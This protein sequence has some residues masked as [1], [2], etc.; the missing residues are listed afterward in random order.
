MLYQNLFI[1]LISLHRPHVFLVLS[2]SLQTPFLF[3]HFVTLQPY[4]KMYTFFPSSI[5]TQ[6]YIMTK[7]QQVFRNAST[8]ITTFLHK[9]SDPFLWDLK[10]SS[11][12]FC[13]HW[14]SLRCFYKWLES[15]FG[16]F[17]WSHS[18]QCMSE[19][20][21]SYELKELSVELRDRI[22]SRHRSGEGYQNKFCNIEGSQEHSGL[23]HS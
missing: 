2:E 20:K 6:Y 21:P 12:A 10:L 13:F 16:Q 23:H 11:R 3:P 15:T 7:R 18:W 9:Y 22:V 5:Y 8:F 17:N 4:S 14:S 19:Q 1:S